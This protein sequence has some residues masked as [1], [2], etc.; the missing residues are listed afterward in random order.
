MIPPVEERLDGVIYIGDDLIKR[1]WNGKGLRKICKNCETYSRNDCDEYCLKCF[2]KDKKTVPSVDKR[3]KDTIYIDDYLIKRKWNGKQF[4]VICKNNCTTLARSGCDGYCLKC[5]SNGGKLVEKSNLSE[6]NMVKDSVYIIDGHR[7]KWDGKR[8]RKTC[9]KCD[10]Y[11]KPDGYC[12]ICTEDTERPKPTIPKKNDR[13][14]GEIYIVD[15]DRKRWSGNAFYRI[16]SRCDSTVKDKGLCTY[17]LNNDKPRKNPRKYKPVFISKIDIPPKSERVKGQIFIGEDKIRRRWNGKSLLKLCLKCDSCAFFGKLC[18][19]HGCPKCK[20]DKCKN[21]AKAPNFDFCIS[22]GGGHR[23]QIKDCPT[24]ARP[25]GGN[26]FC[27]RHGGGKICSHIE[28]GRKCKKAAQ[29]T[30]DFCKGHNGGRRCSH[31]GCPTAANLPFFTC[32]LH[33]GAYKCKTEG[34]EHSKYSLEYEYCFSCKGGPRCSIEDCNDA[35]ASK[36]LCRSHGGGKRCSNCEVNLINGRYNP[37]C[38]YC[39]YE[40]NGIPPRTFKLRERHFHDYFKE[41]VFSD[42][43]YRYDLQI[44][45]GCSK[46]RPDW[47]IDRKTHS[48]IVECDEDSHKDRDNL[49]ERARM[50]E[51]FEDLGDRP[52]VFIRFNP[53]SYLNKNKNKVEGCFTWEKQPQK[54]GTVCITLR[55][56]NKELERRCKRISKRIKHWINNIPK[57]LYTTEYLYYDV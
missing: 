38:T 11:A 12:S 40:L 4:N 15:G 26:K 39:Y 2:N 35:V 9:L 51:I 27:V 47:F 43:K 13:I 28:N 37:Y 55:K 19:K 24:S 34:C 45:G 14:K 29:G 18:K 46:R 7:K 41:N 16:C 31:K 54:S 48:I 42:L 25:R 6:K 32:I 22:H 1:K 33:G 30:T 5:F 44:D 49:C 57:D 3:T 21:K 17:C 23:C 8:L 53:D 10:K 50:S 20:K 56:R 36:M 52:I